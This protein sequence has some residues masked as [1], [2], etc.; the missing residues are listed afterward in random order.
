M[1]PDF[2]DVGLQQHQH[3]FH[4]F[5]HDDCKKLEIEKTTKFCDKTCG[6]T[7]L[8]PSKKKTT[9]QNK[10]CTP[11][12]VCMDLEWFGII[13][14]KGLI[15]PNQ[16]SH[17]FS[18]FWLTTK[19]TSSSTP[20]KKKTQKSN[21]TNKKHPPFFEI[22]PPFSRQNPRTSAP[23][24]VALLKGTKISSRKPAPK[25]CSTWRRSACKAFDVS[26]DGSEPAVWG[27]TRGSSP[28]P[29]D[30]CRVYLPTIWVFLMVNVGKYIN[31]MDPMGYDVVK[32][33]S[34]RLRLFPE[35]KCSRS[36]Q[37]SPW[38]RGTRCWSNVLTPKV[39]SKQRWWKILVMLSLYQL[40]RVCRWEM[41][42]LEV[43]EGFDW[44]ISIEETKDVELWWICQEVQ[45]FKW[46]GWRQNET[47][48]IVVIYSKWIYNI[49]EYRWVNFILEELRLGDHC[50]KPCW[51]CNWWS[52][53]FVDFLNSYR[54]VIGTPQH[55][56]GEPCFLLW[57]S[58][59]FGGQ[60]YKREIWISSLP[61]HE[62][63]ETFAGHNWL[64]L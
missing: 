49:I 39:M 29:E 22:H 54:I 36:S 56:W 21:Q 17:K 34:S 44:H 31:P 10:Y 58:H 38:P 18:F 37:K 50:K 11:A 62:T 33:R 12:E 64:H 26:S 16:Q 3:A 1:S 51:P 55:L 32:I 8:P 52:L 27:L 5:G 13:P 57:F 15:F 24:F 48:Q 41:K 19:K 46:F 53:C 6:R 30:P 2:V 7:G 23:S 47:N 43:G 40:Y 28:Y 63:D 14:N 61:Q 20:P 4:V 42:I 45:L 25:T 59:F 60:A 35:V 9:N